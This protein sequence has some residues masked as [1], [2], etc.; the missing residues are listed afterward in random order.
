M[1]EVDKSWTR[2]IKMPFLSPWANKVPTNNKD[3]N[4]MTN[5]VILCGLYSP[6]KMALMPIIGVI[7]AEIID[8]IKNAF[9]FLLCNVTVWFDH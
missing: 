5:L 8:E 6:L 7:K 2:A 4:Q 9:I 1:A 3:I